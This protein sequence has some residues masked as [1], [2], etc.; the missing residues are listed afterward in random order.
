MSLTSDFFC[1]L[2]ITI[3][4]HITPLCYIAAIQPCNW[5]CTLQNEGSVH[6]TV[7]YPWVLLLKPLKG[8]LHVSGTLYHL[9]LINVPKELWRGTPKVSRCS[10]FD[11]QRASPST[12]LVSLPCNHF[13]PL[14]RAEC[15]IYHIFSLLSTA[16]PSSPLQ[17]L[18]LKKNNPSS[19]VLQKVL[20][21]RGGGM[22]ATV[23]M[24]HQ[25]CP[26]NHSPRF[27]HTPANHA[28]STSTC[29]F[30]YQSVFELLNFS[31]CGLLS[32]ASPS[33]CHFKN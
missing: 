6:S 29:W 18:I 31:C 4:F 7:H 30:I 15:L 20:W 8:S 23:L 12:F 21:R 25:C 9:S 14:P 17:S 11:T 13:W 33:S 19:S 3:D 16:H 26:I 28:V 5:A 2:L 1:L 32:T 24:C 27:L 22:E 10:F